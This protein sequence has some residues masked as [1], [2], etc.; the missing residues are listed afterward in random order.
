MTDSRGV[1]KARGDMGELP[2]FLEVGQPAVFLQEVFS[3]LVGWEL[4][5]GTGPL[6]VPLT[7]SLADTV[8]VSPKSLLRP[9]GIVCLLWAALTVLAQ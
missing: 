6:D 7:G 2:S 3:G 4:S 1:R 9:T 5:E 8:T